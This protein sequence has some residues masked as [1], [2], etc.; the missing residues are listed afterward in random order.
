MKD[1]RVRLEEIREAINLL[2]QE[3]ETIETKL[4]KES[5]SFKG[6]VEIWYDSD[7]KK[8][9]DN[10]F[11]LREY[12]NLYNYFKTCDLNRYATYNFSE[13]FEDE[14]GR[15]LEDQPVD[16]K[17]LLPLKEAVDNNLGSFEYDW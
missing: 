6:Q 1:P 12:P 17:Y 10:V 4:L 15:V 16:E 3:Q 14:I 8:H 11:Q 7:H 2:R 9:V 5:T 13:Y